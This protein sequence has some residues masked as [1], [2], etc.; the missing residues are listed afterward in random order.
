MPKK[1]IASQ[2][3]PE[4]ELLKLPVGATT[5]RGAVRAGGD[6]PSPQCT[7]I[8]DEWALMLGDRA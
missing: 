7:V 2:R 4:P 1:V 3:H 6:P 5:A 8:K